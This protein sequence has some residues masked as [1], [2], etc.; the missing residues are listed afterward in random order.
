MENKFCVSCGQQLEAGAKFCPHCG[1]SQPVEQNQQPQAGTT[2]QQAPQ[3]QQQ[4]TQA[5]PAQPQT[6]PVQPQAQQQTPPVQP[7][8]QQ[9]YQQNGYQQAGQQGQFQ[10]YPQQPGVQTRVKSDLNKFKNAV[11]GQAGPQPELGFIDSVK[12]CIANT[13]DFLTPE[14]RKSVFWWNV[15]GMLLIGLVGL[16]IWII[17]LLGPL[18]YSAVMLGLQIS[19]LAA[20]VRRLRYIGKNPWWVIVPF[21]RVYLLVID[22]PQPYMNQQMYQQNFAGQNQMQQPYQQQY[23]QPQNMNMPNQASQQPLQNQQPMQGQQQTS[24]NDQNTPQS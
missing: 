8:P 12:Y 4:A 14:S 22:K 21:Y 15:L 10:Q 19:F 9:G 20:G 1:A 11:P 3:M 7:N 17:P 5:Q 18:A 13:F 6:P 16:V 23:Q 2:Q 24:N